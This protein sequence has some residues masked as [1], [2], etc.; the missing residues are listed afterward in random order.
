MPPNTPLVDAPLQLESYLKEL[1]QQVQLFGLGGQGAAA[2]LQVLSSRIDSK[3]PVD[4]A[5]FAYGGDEAR[6][7]GVT[8]SFDSVN[9]IA[10]LL[11]QDS[12][13][14]RVE[15]SNAKLAGDNSRVQFEL[16]LKLSGNGGGQ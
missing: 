9:R 7:D 12:L 15:I 1:H 16:Q 6:I 14:R 3:I 5:E 8:D 4:L 11:G 13:F 10:E 2:V